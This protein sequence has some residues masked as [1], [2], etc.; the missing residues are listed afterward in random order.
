MN[1]YDSKLK[2][3]IGKDH[4]LPL[5]LE[6]FKKLE[7]SENNTMLLYFLILSKY[8]YT[9]N[10]KIEICKNIRNRFNKITIEK[11]L[12]ELIKLKLIIKRNEKYELTYFPKD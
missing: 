1:I 4:F 5:K 11:C 12:K 3:A 2:K 8:D 9:N 10:S 7:K 6:C